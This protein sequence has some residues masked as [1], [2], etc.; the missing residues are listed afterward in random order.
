MTVVREVANLD[1]ESVIGGRVT[2]LNAKCRSAMQQQLA[3][4]A[5]AAAAAAHFK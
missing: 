1:G 5:A 3:A 2:K 4:A